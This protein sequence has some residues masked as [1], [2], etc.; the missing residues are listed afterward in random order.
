MVGHVAGLARSMWHKGD[1]MAIHMAI[2]GGHVDQ[3]WVLTWNL[4]VGH[5]GLTKNCLG[6]G[7]NGT[8]SPTLCV[9]DPTTYH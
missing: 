2:V 9:D 5:E 8:R 1:T 3:P 4:E 7:L 6:R